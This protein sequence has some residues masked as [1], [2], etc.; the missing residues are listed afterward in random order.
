MSNSQGLD[1]R[2]EV[3]TSPEP[4]EQT[5]AL[6]G[7]LPPNALSDAVEEENVRKVKKLLKHSQAHSVASVHYT[8]NWLRR[9]QS[10]LASLPCDEKR[11]RRHREASA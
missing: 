10:C 9:G 6:P 5:E 8:W 3:E 4:E 1:A 11:Q 7:Q 2:L